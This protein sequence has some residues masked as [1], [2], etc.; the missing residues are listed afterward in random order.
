MSQKVTICDNTMACIQNV[1]KIKK[2]YQQNVLKNVIHTH[3]YIYIVLLDIFD[4]FM[5]KQHFN[6]GGW[7]GCVS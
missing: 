5:C 1:T 6:V 7:D 2:Y 4:A 3:T